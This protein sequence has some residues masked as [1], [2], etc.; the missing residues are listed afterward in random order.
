MLKA[1]CQKDEYVAQDMDVSDKKMR[2]EEEHFEFALNSPV[3]FKQTPQMG[4]NGNNDRL[5]DD[6]TTLETN[7]KSNSEEPV[8]QIE[9]VTA[10]GVCYDKDAECKNENLDSFDYSSSSG[11]KDLSSEAEKENDS[12]EIAEEECVDFQVIAQQAEIRP[13]TCEQDINVPSSQQ[14]QCDRVTGTVMPPFGDGSCDGNDGL[15]RE[16][17]EDV[18]EEDLPSKL[19]ADKLD[20]HLPQFEQ[21][22]ET[23]QKGEN[24]LTCN[25]E[26]AVLCDGT[27]QVNEEMLC[28][29]SIVA[30]IEE[31]QSL[32]VAPPCLIDVRDDSLTGVTTD[33]KAQISDTEDFCDLSLDC[34]LQ[35]E[36][37]IAPS[38]DGDT[39]AVV[40][41]PQMQVLTPCKNSY[42]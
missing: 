22:A 14:E 37:Q 39:E 31:S 19:T 24:D 13:L 23:E 17:I 42:Y 10:P 3:C 6:K 20:T 25:Q 1:E 38:L 11:N 15:A 4:E 34:H 30:C 33:A 36:D 9:D 41:S 12:S 35:R 21:E 18:V 2:P 28:S 26:D 29:D 7:S 16:V 27:D 5:Q 40:I 32:S 8:N